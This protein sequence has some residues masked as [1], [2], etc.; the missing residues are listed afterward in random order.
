MLGV[1]VS[2]ALDDVEKQLHGELTQLD[3]FVGEQHTAAAYR[4][5]A[6]EQHGWDAAAAGGGAAGSSHVD[7][8]SAGG[9]SA[10]GSAEA[11]VVERGVALLWD[12]LKLLP[13]FRRKTLQAQH[14]SL[15]ARQ[16]AAEGERKSAEAAKR[17]AEAAAQRAAAGGGEAEVV[18][19]AEEGDAVGAGAQQEQQEQQEQGQEATRQQSPAPAQQQQQ[20]QEGG[21]A[22][23]PELAG[24][25][26]AVEA[27]HEFTAAGRW[28][29]RIKGYVFKTGSSGLGY[30]RDE[31][32]KGEA[33]LGQVGVGGCVW[34]VRVQGSQGPAPLQQCQFAGRS[35]A[36]C[37]ARALSCHFVCCAAAPRGRRHATSS[38]S[39]SSCSS[40]SSSGSG[41]LPFFPLPLTSSSQCPHRV[42]C[43]CTT[44]P[45]QCPA[46]C[47]STSGGWRV[48]LGP[49]PPALGPS[50]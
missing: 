19:V 35:P 36:A 30:Y 1:R 37:P 34:R 28:L 50:A 33:S 14:V 23:G 43:S 25:L 5:L 39:S 31:P 10:A 46:P 27:H 7:S 40:S 22:A 20:Q 17:R 45:P 48:P 15:F 16:L 8:S 13:D 3:R 4:R 26:G 18:E 38:S 24:V 42:P 44:W 49:R 29:G 21:A 11:A 6:R 41:R 12:I 2:A 9:G 47:R 32:P